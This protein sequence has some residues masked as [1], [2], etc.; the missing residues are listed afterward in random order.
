MAIEHEVV[1][2][3]LPLADALKE[4]GPSD[5]RAAKVA[6]LF[7]AQ[8]KLSWEHLWH[9]FF[10]DAQAGSYSIYIHRAA[11]RVHQPPLSKYGAIEV[12][13]V[14]T[15]WCALFGVEVAS[16]YA[17]MQDPDNVQ[18]VFVSDS[19]VPLKPFSYVYRELVRNSPTTSKICLA[20]P[21]PKNGFS[22]RPCYF[23]DFLREVNP[24]TLKHH[25]WAV[26][27][28]KHAKFIVKYAREALDIYKDVWLKSAPQ[29]PRNLGSCSDEAVPLIA[30]LHALKAENKSTGMAGA[31]S[32]FANITVSYL[33]ELL[34]QGFMFARKF[35]PGMLIKETSASGKS[36]AL[37]EALPTLWSQLDQQTAHAS[38]W[39]RLDGS[40]APLQS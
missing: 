40:G 20:S 35:R 37:D 10:K 21:Q 38:Q 17:A 32:A 2:P 31:P 8:T 33:H 28:R 5:P 1:E 26:F 6:F 9:E 7:L 25:Q 3:F 23:P 13:W 16:L 39:S 34:A 18:F 14:K 22:A 29:F 12:P 30:L 15:A 24:R 19:A 36:I 4:Q 11:F 27:N